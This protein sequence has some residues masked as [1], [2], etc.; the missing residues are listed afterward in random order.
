M[1]YRLDKVEDKSAVVELNAVPLHLPSLILGS[2]GSRGEQIAPCGDCWLSRQ[3]W[4]RSISRSLFY[5]RQ[6]AANARAKSVAGNAHIRLLP[7]NF[8]VL[9]VHSYTIQLRGQLY[10][11]LVSER[12]KQ[13]VGSKKNY[14][15]THRGMLH[16]LLEIGSPQLLSLEESG[17]THI[18]VIPMM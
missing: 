1:R 12:E 13:A 9:A 18:P 14:R 10:R 8:R 4:Q 3:A 2:R 16:T 15:D 11:K 7:L 5:S 6:H 17:H